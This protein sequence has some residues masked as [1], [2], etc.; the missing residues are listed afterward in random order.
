MMKTTFTILGGGLAGLC[1]AIRLAE[2][3]VEPLLIEAGT[4]PSHKVC[5]EFLSPASLPLLKSW[6]IIPVP[7]YQAHLRTPQ[8]TL[9]FNFPSPAGSLSHLQLD[10]ALAIYAQK[11]GVK[12]LTATKVAN[13]IPALNS[14]TLHQLQLDSGQVIQTTHLLIATGRL[15]GFHSPSPTLCY[16]GIKAHFKEIPIQNTLEMFAF[17]GAY[18]GLSPVE[19]DCFNVACLARS[20]LVQQA[21]SSDAFIHTLRQKHPLLNLYLSQ[22]KNLFPSW[23]QVSIPEFGIKSL[24]LWPRTYFIGDAAGTIPPASGNGLSMAL[25]SGYLAAEYAIKNDDH[26]FKKAWHKR[27]A[28]P[29]RMGKC[30]HHLML[31]PHYSNFFLRLGSVFPSLTQSIFNHTR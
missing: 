4:Y 8:K 17:P 28:H 6:N 7:L 16:T 23:M 29:I 31:R 27:Y 12:L 24:P 15:P 14:F 26:G 30:L 18:L 13:L 22:G 5:G 2:L 9:S 20:E 11:L 25:T 10:P 21:G 3:G 19:N 1:A